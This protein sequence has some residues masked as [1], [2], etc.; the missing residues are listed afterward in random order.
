MSNHH[1][2]RICIGNYC[3]HAAQIRG[4]THTHRAVCA[5]N[6]CNLHALCQISHCLIA[7]VLSIQNQAVCINCKAQTAIFVFDF[8]N[9]NTVCSGFLYR[10]NL[11]AFAQECSLSLLCVLCGC[12]HALGCLCRCAARKCCCACQHCQHHTHCHNL[13]H[14]LFHI[15]FLLTKW[16][17][18]VFCFRCIPIRRNLFCKSSAFFKKFS[19]FYC[20]FFQTKR[21]A[22]SSF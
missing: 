5:V 4:Q 22:I 1:I 18:I 7:A 21:S 19:D 17:G 9:G 11:A 2:V 16:C 12:Q 10:N 8:H 6:H 13:C 15:H 3:C 20:F 14:I